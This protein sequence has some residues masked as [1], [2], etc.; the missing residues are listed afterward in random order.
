MEKPTLQTADWNRIQCYDPATGRNLGTVPITPPEEIPVL[1]NRCREAQTQW[2]QTSLTVRKQVLRSLLD[3]VV[4]NQETICKISARDTGK[5]FLDA[6]LGEILTTCEKIKWTLQHGEKALRTEYREAG[7]VLKYKYAMVVYEPIGVQAAIVSWNYPFHNIVGPIITALFAGNGIMVKASEYASWSAS[8]YLKYIRDIIAATGN[9][10]DIVQLVIGFKE[11]GKALVKAPVDHITF[12][13]STAVGKEIM[14]AAADNLTPCVLELGGKDCLILRS[15]CNVDQ[16]LPLVLRG[17]FQNCGQN[18]IGIERILA[19]EAVYDTLVDRLLERV[20]QFKQ[21]AP[22]D[23]P[24]IDQGAMTMGEVHLQKLTALVEDAVA[25]GARVRHGGHVVKHPRF[26][27][28]SYFAPTVLTGV[29]PAM[30]IA[31]TDEHFGP[32][33]VLMGPYAT[34]AELIAAANQ[35]SFGLGSS[36][37]TANPAQG[38]DALA[39]RLRTGMCNINDFGVNYI[40]QSLPF[41]GVGQSGFGRLA[42][43]EGIRGVCLTRAITRDRFPAWIRTSIPAVLQY[44]T[45]SDR[46]AGDFAMALVNMVYSATWASRAAALVVLAKLGLA[47]P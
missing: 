6:Q 40:C 5:T 3:F 17:V 39:R 15:D 12:I 20:R 37:F 18:C 21:G 4:T 27:A 33:A 29:T 9:N 32:V 42:G 28:G 47:N 22:L 26:P 30:R 2:A 44:P 13:G 1:L 24:N 34:D 31:R 35:C 16:T 41:G 38:Y 36:V 7:T 8:I 25:Q 11:S 46:A 14:A 43:Y 23:E 10:P 45:R 19:H